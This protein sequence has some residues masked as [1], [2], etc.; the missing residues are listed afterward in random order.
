GGLGGGGAPGPPR[1]G[2][3]GG[4]CGGWRVGGLRGRRGGIRFWVG[5]AGTAR[6]VRSSESPAPVTPATSSRRWPVS[7]SNRTMAPKGRGASPAARQIAPASSSLSTRS[8]LVT[9]LTIGSS[10]NGLLGNVPRFIAQA[11]QARP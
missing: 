10:A 1:G 4:G 9:G 8:R 11:K 5:V 7:I 6:V 3:G 2:G